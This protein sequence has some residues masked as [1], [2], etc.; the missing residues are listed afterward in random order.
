MFLTFPFTSFILQTLNEPMTKKKNV[1]KD[2]IPS[3]PHP[4]SK[5]LEIQILCS[6]EGGEVTVTWNLRLELSE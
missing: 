1:S 2:R 3:H 6:N 4:F 5:L